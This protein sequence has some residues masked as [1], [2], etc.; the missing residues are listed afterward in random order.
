MA[1]SIG[2]V[3]LS[4]INEAD[5]CVTG[6]KLANISSYE[7]TNDDLCSGCAKGRLTVKPFTNNNVQGPKTNEVLQLVG[8]D[9]M[10]LMTPTSFGRLASLS[11][12][13]CTVLLL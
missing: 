1:C 3:P 8:S 10:G 7:S 6:L 2:H 12:R 5:K 4:K 13:Q 11:R 9:I